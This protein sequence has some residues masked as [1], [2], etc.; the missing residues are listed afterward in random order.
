[1]QKRVENMIE[2]ITLMAIVSLSSIL[3][4]ASCKRCIVRKGFIWIWQR[5]AI[6]RDNIHCEN[7]YTVHEK[8]KSQRF[9]TE[10]KESCQCR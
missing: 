6:S 8:R 7:N 5:K 4:L 2:I 1:M 3:I 9:P 10:L